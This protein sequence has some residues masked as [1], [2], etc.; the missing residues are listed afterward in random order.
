MINKILKFI[1]RWE[2]VFLGFILGLFLSEIPT[3]PAIAVLG[4]ICSVILI[5]GRYGRLFSRREK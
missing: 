2:A 1:D 4:I 3:R 5:I